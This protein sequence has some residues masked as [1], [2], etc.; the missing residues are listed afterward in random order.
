[1][2]QNRGQE[3]VLGT[4]LKLMVTLL[5]AMAVVK[6]MDHHQQTD[7]PRMAIGGCNACDRNCD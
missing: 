6:Y 2:Q 1:M 3:S 5:V 4:T 7:K